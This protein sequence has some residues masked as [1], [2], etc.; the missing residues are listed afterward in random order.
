[1]NH[2]EAKD[3]AA[4]TELESATNAIKKAQEEAFSAIAIL[5]NKLQPLSVQRLPDE[6]VNE[7][8]GTMQAKRS[9]H[10][11]N[12]KA[13][14]QSTKQLTQAISNTTSSLDY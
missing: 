2:N 12:L 10:I 5:Q 6:K 3:C 7:T 11:E 9:D 8:G 4:H 1:M 13:I 14:L